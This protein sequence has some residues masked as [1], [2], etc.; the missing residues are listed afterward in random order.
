MKKTVNKWLL[1]FAS[2]FL[3]M[4][5]ACSNSAG[6]GDGNDN[7][8]DSGETP[9]TKP[10]PTS[11]APTVINDDTYIG[12]KIQVK[13]S[14]IPAGAYVREIY[15]NDKQ[16]GGNAFDTHDDGSITISKFVTATEWGYPFVKAGKTYNVYIKYLDKSYN[17]IQQTKPVTITATKGLGELYCPNAAHRIEK[18][19]LKFTKGTPHVLY[20][21]GTNIGEYPN[22]VTNSKPSYVLNIYKADDWSYQTWNWLGEGKDFEY[23]QN[24]NFAKHLKPGADLTKQ[25]MFNVVCTIND[26]DYG[27]YNYFI[28]DT[29]E[30]KF[31]I[32]QNNLP[33]DSIDITQFIPAS[34]DL[35][36]KV[37]TDTDRSQYITFENTEDSNGNLNGKMY[38]ASHNET[39]GVYT[40]EE[41]SISYKNGILNSDEESMT[42]LRDGM[43]NYCGFAACTKISGEGIYGTYQLPA[44]ASLTLTNDGKYSFI[45]GQGN[46][47]AESGIIN[48]KDGPAKHYFALYDGKTIHLAVFFYEIIPALPNPLPDPTTSSN[49]GTSPSES[50]V[51]ISEATPENKDLMGKFLH[52]S[53]YVKE[54]IDNSENYTTE[55]RDIYLAFGTDN[56]TGTLSVNMTSYNKE[57][58]KICEQKTY[59]YKNGLLTPSTSS[60]STSSSSSYRIFHV[61]NKFYINP[62]GGELDR[63]SGEGL[64][65]SFSIADLTITL[66]DK[67]EYT[68]SSGGHSI[69]GQYTNTYGVIT[70]KNELQGD[71]QMLYDGQK[72][73]MLKELI[74]ASS[75]PK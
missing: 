43:D 65:S 53:E 70:L 63:S 57:H 21:D 17:G 46:F 67:G 30:N 23:N 11:D 60:S 68:Y 18:N 41:T 44:G 5:V 31:Y 28:A 2:I 72:L 64:N 48:F 47:T 32:D 42:L 9:V 58:T 24:F 20:G 71:G 45:G 12:I 74:E 13:S 6:G 15:V 26:K 61:M 38:N 29:I 39:T 55:E 36:G 40:W 51:N 37:L 52:Y 3:M 49:N 10:L 56:S 66:T 14:D 8:G 1:L 35:R 16:V 50:F 33:G 25:Y 27:D 19:I 34:A 7:G 73:Y 54:H 22:R 75:L 69:T 4:T 62:Y 59:S